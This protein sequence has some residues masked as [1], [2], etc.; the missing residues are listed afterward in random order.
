[1][2]WCLFSVLDGIRVWVC[3]WGY[4]GVLFLV[5]VVVIIVCCRW[6]LLWLCDVI[7]SGLMLLVLFILLG[8]CRLRCWDRNWFVGLVRKWCSVFRF[9]LV[10]RFVVF[11]GGSV[12]V[13]YGVSVWWVLFSDLVVGCYCWW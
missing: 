6:I 3:R 1:M 10:F 13:N 4:N 11:D 5:S 7:I 9:R 12:W 8:R 2:N